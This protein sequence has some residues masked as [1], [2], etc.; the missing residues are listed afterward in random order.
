[1]TVKSRSIR[2]E[3]VSWKQFSVLAR[4]LALTILSSGFQAD[5]IVAIG[6]GGYMPARLLSDYL[7]IFN[8]TSFKIEHYRRTEKSADTVVRYPLSVDLS[9]LKVLLVDDVSD[10][11]DTLTVAVSHLH[12]N[13]PPA[14][15]RTAVLHHKQQSGFVPNYY[16]AEIIEWRWLIYPWAL[17][18]D[19]SGFIQTLKLD[20]STPTEMRSNIEQYYAVSIPDQALLDAQ[21]IVRRAEVKSS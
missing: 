12:E 20:Q 2:C 11:G 19:V 1:M 16:A 17:L 21:A 5:I 8:L 7:D 9:G 18:E 4:E 13:G 6:R 10:G 14:E 3:L 15:I